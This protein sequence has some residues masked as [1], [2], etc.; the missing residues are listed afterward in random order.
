MAPPVQ[1]SSPINSDEN[2]IKP[3]NAAIIPRVRVAPQPTPSAA[4]L[5]RGLETSVSSLNLK[6]NA[7]VAN[8][9]PDQEPSST[10]RPALRHDDE[11]T[12]LSSSSTKPA[13]LDG[14]SVTSGTTFAMDEKESL[15]PDDSASV[16]AAEDDDS[17]PASGA[18]SSR[19]GSEAGGRVFQDQFNEIYGGIGP[20]AQPGI[21][22]NRRQ[23]PGIEEEAP[24]MPPVSVVPTMIAPNIIPLPDVV[25]N[26]GSTFSPF[27]YQDP[28]EKL[29]EALESPKDR[30]FLL[31]LEQDV[32]T[33]IMDPKYVQIIVSK[34]SSNIVLSEPLI[35][36]LPPCNS[37]C[38]LLA[39]KLADYYAL[40]HFVDN[41]VSAVRL[42]R[43]PYCRL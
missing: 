28:D 27:D 12:N 25:Q 16:K 1:R 6:E 23:I 36:D 32:I 38:R 34:L 43:T 37:F 4:Q 20:G 13:S 21:P 17:G 31:R 9:M 14:K 33:F 15:R 5:S 11:K 8:G 3:M 10:L 29:F 22:S 2:Q 18:P 41:A 35:L 19:I 26:N 39:H 7:V 30:L 40:T 24:Q 42:Y